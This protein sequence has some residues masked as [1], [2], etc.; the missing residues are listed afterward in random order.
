MFLN[1]VVALSVVLMSGFANAQVGNDP[2]KD[3]L[4]NRSSFSLMLGS[5]RLDF[6]ISNMSSG[7]PGKYLSIIGLRLVSSNAELT[8]DSLTPFCRLLGFRQG[9][10][11]YGRSWLDKLTMP[12]YGL[13]LSPTRGVELVDASSA[14][15]A[16]SVD[17][18]N[19]QEDRP[20]L[21]GE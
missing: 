7:V 9:M 17:C 20:F 19:R 4:S 15:L 6:K 1:C 14:K 18:F 2:V 13:R 21:G 8:E 11:S 10:G 12:S 5:Q 3:I 16:H